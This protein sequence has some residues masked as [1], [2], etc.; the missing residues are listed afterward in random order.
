V[1]PVEVQRGYIDQLGRG[2]NLLDQAAHARDGRAAEQLRAEAQQAF[3][4]AGRLIGDTGVSLGEVGSVNPRTGDFDPT[5]DPWVQ[6][7][8]ANL[9]E[10]LGLM[11]KGF[12][13]PEPDPWWFRVAMERFDK[14][15]EGLA[16]HA[17]IGV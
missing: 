15:Y 11:A 9:V 14:A 13:D 10:G 12:C 3:E 16:A 2:V 8:A 6:D 17:P 1:L 4:G 7:T 5:P